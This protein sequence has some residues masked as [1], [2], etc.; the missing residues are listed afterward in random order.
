MYKSFFV[1]CLF[2]FYLSDNL[3]DN[4]MRT[5]TINTVQDLRSF[6]EKRSSLQ[7]L[8]TVMHIRNYGVMLPIHTKDIDD[9]FDA[10]KAGIHLVIGC[11]RL[12]EAQ[13]FAVKSV[14]DMYLNQCMGITRQTLISSNQLLF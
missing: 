12:D 4:N 11:S 14:C 9:A 3:N 13:T 2:T 8:D 5:I 7:R 10:V 1:I 6:M